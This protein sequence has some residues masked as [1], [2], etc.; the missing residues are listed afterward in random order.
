[1]AENAGK[2]GSGVL[3]GAAPILTLL[4]LATVATLGAG[5]LHIL[6]AVYETLF[7]PPDLGSIAFERVTRRASGND[8]LACPPGECGS[9]KVDLKPP[10][11]TGSASEL[12]QRVRRYFAEQGAVLVG[13]DDSS[14]HD[15]FVVRT[16]L[17]R[18]PDTV[19]VQIFPADAEHATLAAYSRSQLGSGDMGTN[20]ERLRALFDALGPGVASA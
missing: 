10:S 14:L 5:Q 4:I 17:L 2:R 12:R 8:A 6:D 19:D 3:K 1:M 20:L 13:A 9:A 7:G 18:F 16:R 15:R 11:Y